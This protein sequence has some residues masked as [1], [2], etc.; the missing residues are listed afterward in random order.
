MR[1][2]LLLFLLSLS[3]AA[4]AAQAPAEKKVYHTKHINPHPPQL[5]GK[6][7]DPVWEKL[8]WAGDF[9]QRE[10]DDGKAP[11]QQTN[12]K[13]TYDDKNLYLA[14]R[15]HDSE[16]DKIV[17]RVTRRDQ[18]DGDWLE[19][20]IDSYFDHRTGFSFTINAAGVQGDEAISNDGDNWDSNWNP[21]WEAVVALDDGGWNA[22]IR[23]PFSQL[24]F[25]EKPE[26]V[27]G[28]QVQRRL[29]RK[30]ERSV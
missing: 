1:N 3:A 6:F 5:D 23:I 14:I 9:T 7:E 24:R 10:P 2:K 20:N 25:G 21:V 29:F 30:Q 8:D 18:F 19:V 17:R 4:L 15:A 22:E 12:F 11:S 13:I 28:I 27:W 26:H 16:P